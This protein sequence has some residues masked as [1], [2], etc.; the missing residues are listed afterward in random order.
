VEWQDRQR[1]QR[2]TKPGAE[3]GQR[4]KQHGQAWDQPQC[5]EQPNDWLSDPCV[6]CDPDAERHA[7][8]DADQQCSKAQQEVLAGRLSEGRLPLEKVLIG[9][10]QELHSH[11][12]SFTGSGR[13]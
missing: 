1:Q 10:E 5:A 3:I 8:T 4:Q 12:S 13:G 7:E 2:G 6:I 9:V 11:P